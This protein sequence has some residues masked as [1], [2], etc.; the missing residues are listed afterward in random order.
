[1]M[2]FSRENISWAGLAF[3]TAS[4]HSFLA[5]PIEMKVRNWSWELQM[6]LRRILRMSPWTWWRCFSGHYNCFLTW[7]SKV[8]L[9]VPIWLWPCAIAAAIAANSALPIVLVIPAHIRLNQTRVARTGVVDT[10]LNNLT[11]FLDTAATIC[12]GPGLPVSSL[13]C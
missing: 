13:E 10:C 4:A 6:V 1:M 12:L 3:D 7:W 11:A 2:Y 8:R 5:I 9:S